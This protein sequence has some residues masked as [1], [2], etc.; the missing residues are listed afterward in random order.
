MKSKGVGWG[1]RGSDGELE[2]RMG[3]ERAGWGG[4]GGQKGSEGVG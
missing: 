1:V 3:T 4:G 2:G